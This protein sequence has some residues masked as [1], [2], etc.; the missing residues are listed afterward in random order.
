MRQLTDARQPLFL[1]PQ[2]I[3]DM[4]NISDNGVSIISEHV[5]NGCAG[6]V[7]FL[8]HVEVWMRFS[9]TYRGSLMIK[10]TSPSG[11]V[12]RLLR[13]RWY[14]IFNETTDW[15][16]MTVHSWGERSEGTW[17]LQVET[18]DS[19]TV[20][21]LESWKL[22]LYGTQSPPLNNPAAQVSVEETSST[23]VGAIVGGVVGGIVLFVI[24]AVLLY[25]FV[26]KKPK[27]PTVYPTSSTLAAESGNHGTNR[28]NQGDDGGNQGAENAG[29]QQE[30]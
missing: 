13:P 10:L 24:V 12:S 3:L 30:T 21:G 26:L 1:Q 20:F 17:K 14:D 11:T 27:D 4:A 15:T 16:F 28:G 23:P 9:A 5:S 2:H 7:Q 19:T 6:A 22:I 18:I 8:E 25:M 29:F